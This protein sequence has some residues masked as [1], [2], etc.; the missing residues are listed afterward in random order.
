[1]GFSIQPRKEER[2]MK[3]TDIT[4]QDKLNEL[5]LDISHPKS[6]GV[7]FIF[8]EGDSDIRLFRKFFNLEKCKVENIPGGNV[9]LE[10]CVNTLVDIY[11]LVIGIRDSDFIRLEEIEYGLK[12]MFLTDL[13]DME[14]TIINHELVLNALIFEYSSAP[15][16]SHIELRNKIFDSISSLSCLKWLNFKENLELEFSSGFQDLICF[17]NQNIDLSQYIMRVLSKSPNAKIT[18][19]DVLIEKILAL[20]SISP[21]IMQLTNGHDI[22]N[23]FA[24]YFRENEGRVGVSKETLESSI[25]MVYDKN[26][27]NITELYSSL[28]NWQAENNTV[29]F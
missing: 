28:L 11:P 9:K 5:R 4:Y 2:L 26:A 21:D 15:K 8:V 10:E 3:K 24:K 12:N 17:T 1:M 29:L 18:S 20:K 7:N 16:E 23:V 14:I 27:F 25:R 22:L 19:S 13:H 6:S